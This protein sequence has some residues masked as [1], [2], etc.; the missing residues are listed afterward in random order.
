MAKRKKA[1]SLPDVETP[2]VPP[3]PLAHP[4]LLRSILLYAHDL[5]LAN[6]LR[7]NHLF[8]DIAGSIL[9]RALDLGVCQGD[10][11]IDGLYW[12]DWTI[13]KAVYREW[14]GKQLYP[15]SQARFVRRITIVFPLQSALRVCEWAFRSLAILQ[16]DMIGQITFLNTESL[17]R[18]SLDV[19]EG[20]TTQDHFRSCLF[21][22]IDKHMESH[23]QEERD[24]V[25]AKISCMGM[26]EY[27][28]S[29]DWEGEFE[30]EEV[31]QWLD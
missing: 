30:P 6:C 12:L 13:N 16:Y 9:Y 19:P 1:K 28:A 11:P 7:V 10:E 18:E 25:H 14:R 8:F 21:T 27:L 29:H 2:S 22:A 15:H 17:D 5:T 26:R 23:T 20:V 4:D 31:R 24:A 3:S